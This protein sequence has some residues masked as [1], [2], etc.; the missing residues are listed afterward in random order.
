MLCKHTDEAKDVTNGGHKYNK[1]VDQ[2]EEAESNGDVS[3]PVERLVRKKDLKQGPANLQV[4]DMK[5][6][7][8]HFF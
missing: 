7:S 2:E 1:Q 6:E 8:C 3:G 4:H 5:V